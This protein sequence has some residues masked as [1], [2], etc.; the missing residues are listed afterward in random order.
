MK[1]I[2]IVEVG[3]RDGFQNIKQQ[4][5]MENKLEVIRLLCES[6]VGQMEIGSFVNPKAIPQMADM[7]ELSETVM[8]RHEGM[9]RPIALI[10]N[11][12][13]AEDACACHIDTVTYVISV[14]KE[15]NLANVRKTPEESMAALGEVIRMFPKLHVRL[16][17]AT[18]FGC[19]YEG[20]ISTERV[21]T[22]AKQAEQLGVREFILCDTIGVAAPTQVQRLAETMQKHFSNSTIGLHLHDTRGLGLANIY[23][24]W[25][26]GIEL[27]ETSVGGLG[28]CPFAPGAAGNTA[29]EDLLYMA[30][31][32]GLETGIV[33]EKYLLAVQ[34]VKDHIQAQLTGRQL[35]ACRTNCSVA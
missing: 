29:T 2:Q 33:W 19:P 1:R 32:M 11:I 22:L 31:R 18:S 13:G 30:R 35:D 5:P 16:D 21:V 10:P 7:R 27:F 8:Q 6:G 4:I 34:Y 3:P 9:F 26:C 17:L 28:G 15:H 24:G 25:C 23:A 12:R 20:E 14:S